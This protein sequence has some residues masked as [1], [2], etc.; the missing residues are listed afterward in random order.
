MPEGPEIHRAANRIAKALVGKTLTDVEFHYKT[1]E[2][3]EHFFLDKKVE[4]VK[5]RSKGLLISVGDYVMYSHNQLY[6]RWTVNRSTTKP[7]PTNRSLRVLFGN[8]KNT[9]RLW[10]ATDI[11]ILEPW[12]LP[13]H[14]YLAKLGP[15]VADLAV[16]YDDVLAQVSNP[17]FARRQLSG[18]MLDQGFLAGVGNYLRS[19]ILFDA[20]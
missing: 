10:S 18:L 12:E 17:K 13:G 19:E 9:A 2:G 3:L 4:Y 14:P 20:G 16:Q 8:Q 7:K 1:V 6:G 15:D 5:A 11:E